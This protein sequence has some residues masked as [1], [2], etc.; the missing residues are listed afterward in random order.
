MS[1]IPPVTLVFGEKY[2]S[3]NTIILAKKKFLDYQFETLSASNFN[4]DDIRAEIGTYDW[5]ES[6]KVFIIEDF[7]NNNETREF[8]LDICH[9]IPED[10]SIILFDTTNSIKIDPKTHKPTKLWQQF[11][12]ELS[13]IKGTKII[14]NGPEYTE[15]DEADCISFIRKVFDKYG[16]NCG[17]KEA[18]LL[19]KISGMDKGILISEIE[20]IALVAD[21]YVGE[22]VILENAFYVNQ[23]AILYKFSNALDACS[24]QKVFSSVEEFISMG[25]NPNVLAEIMMKKARWQLAASYYYSC[26]LPWN[27]VVDKIMEMGE[28]P[29][30]IYHNSEQSKEGKNASAELYQDANGVIDFMN[31]K[32]GIPKKY[33]K[34]KNKKPKILKS[35]KVSTAKPKNPQGQTEKMPMRFMASQVTCFLR[36]HVVSKNGSESNLRIRVLNR[37]IRVYLFLYEKLVEIRT[38]RNPKQSLIEM[39]LALTDTKI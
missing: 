31:I 8:L 23:E 6:K 18:T 38:S 36:D 13:N 26:K 35:G 37:A 27:I 10:K 25:V 29:S 7:H 5:T 17:E 12:D 14:N 16:K 24:P 33:F 9:N 19:M 3:K 20:K 32:Q 30:F 15:K 2:I 39:G 22:N 21:E 4:C 34:L 28:F 1:N 11:I